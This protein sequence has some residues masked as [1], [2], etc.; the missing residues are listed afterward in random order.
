MFGGV[1]G[2]VSC[3]SDSPSCSSDSPSWWCPSILGDQA[4]EMVDSGVSEG[5]EDLPVVGVEGSF[6]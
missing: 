1:N 4:A 2:K 3:S 5:D 6:P